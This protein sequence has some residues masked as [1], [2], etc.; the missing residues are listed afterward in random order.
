MDTLN[1]FYLYQYFSP[2]SKDNDKI[3]NCFRFCTIIKYIYALHLIS[4]VEMYSSG[5]DSNNIKLR[6]REKLLAFNIMSEEEIQ[7]NCSIEE[8]CFAIECNYE[9]FFIL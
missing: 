7:E 1:Q 3:D 4:I 6:L 2:I 9:K 8:L 5:N